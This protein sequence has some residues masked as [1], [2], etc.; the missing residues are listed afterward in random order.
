MPYVTD[1][2]T[3]DIRD[4][5]KKFQVVLMPNAPIGT[6]KF[7]GSFDTVEQAQGFCDQYSQK[8]DSGG[9]EEISM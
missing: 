7:L 4:H 5:A 6:G 9:N 2:A 1:A 3:F 8:G